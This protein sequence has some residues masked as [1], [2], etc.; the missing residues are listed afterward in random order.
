MHSQTRHYMKWSG[1]FH[2]SAIG[3][4]PPIGSHCMTGWRVPVLMWRRQRWQQ[5]LSLARMKP[6][7]VII[8]T[9]IS[10][11]LTM[12]LETALWT[13]ATSLDFA[14]QTLHHQLF[15][16]LTY[17]CLTLSVE[18]CPQWRTSRRILAAVLCVVH[19]NLQNAVFCYVAACRSCEKR[20]FGGTCRLHLQDRK[21]NSVHRSRS[22]SNL[23]ETTRSSETLFLTR[24]IQW[25]HLRKLH[26]P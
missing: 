11:F 21:T 17:Y 6:W 16:F 7:P 19:V 8:R 26:S 2:A 24:T 20:C 3:K 5:S 23:E 22:T 14:V 15:G 18:T 25:P 12:L 10:W 4:D 9:D 1:E 13:H